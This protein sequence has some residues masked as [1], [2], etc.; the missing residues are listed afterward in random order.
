MIKYFLF[1][2]L[3]RHI[4]VCKLMDIGHKNMKK[5]HHIQLKKGIICSRQVCGYGR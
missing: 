5:I 2:Y 4:H 1:N 3:P